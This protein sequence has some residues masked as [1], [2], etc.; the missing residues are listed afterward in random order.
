[1][2]TQK[3]FLSHIVQ[4]KTEI[5]SLV[6][7]G[8]LSFLSHI[9]QTKTEI[10]SL[11]RDG[12]LSFLSHIVQT[13]TLL[14]YRI[15]YREEFFLSHIVQTKTLKFFLFSCVFVLY[16]VDTYTK[17]ILSYSINN[18]LCRIFFSNFYYFISVF[19]SYCWF[20]CIFRSSGFIVKSF[21]SFFLVSF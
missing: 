3:T 6:R 21:K 5:V 13:K 16:I 10:V 9:V 7:D 19:V 12:K 1:M 4:T 20:S 14:R 8:K 2:K 15:R 18:T 11:V 17:K